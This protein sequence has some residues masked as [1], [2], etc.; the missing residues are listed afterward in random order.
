MKT[1]L[2]GCLTLAITLFSIPILIWFGIQLY[3]SPHTDHHD[4]YEHLGW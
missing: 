1:F 3:A 2:S 4:D